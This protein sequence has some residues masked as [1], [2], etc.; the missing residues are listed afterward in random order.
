MYPCLPHSITRGRGEPSTNCTEATRLCCHLP[1]GPSSVALQSNARMRSAISPFQPGQP[2]SSAVN[3]IV[4]LRGC[5]VDERVRASR[6]GFADKAG[7]GRAQTGD[8]R[9]AW[10]TLDDS[11]YL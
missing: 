9:T 11:R 3:G 6:A 10:E 4:L 7:W 1:I 5:Q 8:G 2:W